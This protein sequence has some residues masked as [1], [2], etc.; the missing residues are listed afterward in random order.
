MRCWFVLCVASLTWSCAATRP[1]P[2][3]APLSERDEATLSGAPIGALL[4]EAERGNTEPL[5]A[6]LATGTG[7][8]GLIDGGPTLLMLASASG[9][10]NVVELLLD[11]GAAIDMRDDQ[12]ATALMFAANAGQTEIV[13]LLLARGANAS[14]RSSSG[15]TALQIASERKHRDV[16]RL[17]KEPP[18]R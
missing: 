13:E 8:N 12:G 18:A 10:T 17:L 16:V 7:L 1:A 9:Q 2:E 3:S 4:Q 15:K 5:E 14:I 11:R 6:L